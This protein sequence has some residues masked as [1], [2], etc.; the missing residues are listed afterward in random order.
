MVDDEAPLRSAVASYFRS[1]GHSVETTGT[2]RDAIIRAARE[3]FDVVLLDIRLPDLTGDAVQAELRR[4]AP[5]LAD[6]VVFVTGD[7]Q[8]EVTRH[9]LAAAGRPV[10]S[11][12]FLFEDLATIALG[13]AAGVDL[14]A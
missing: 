6:R 11:K 2:G 9:M 4:I 8:S 14:G 7:T 5:A 10:V 13:V 3:T 1:L 12:P